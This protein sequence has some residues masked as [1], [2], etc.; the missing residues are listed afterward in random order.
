MK[1]VIFLIIILFLFCNIVYADPHYCYI[2]KEENE[3]VILKNGD[4]I[5]VYFSDNFGDTLLK[6]NFKLYY[7]PYVFEIVKNESGEYVYHDDYVKIKNAKVYS[8]IIEF[9]VEGSEDISLEYPTMYIKFKVKDSAKEGSTII[10]LINNSSSITSIYE[11]NFYSSDVGEYTKIDTN[12]IDCFNAKL[13]YKI[14]NKSDEVLLDSTYSYIGVATEGT[15]MYPSYSPEVTDYVVEVYNDNDEEIG[16]EIS[17]AINGECDNQEYIKVDYKKTKNLK[18]TS[19]NGSSS[20]TYNFKINVID[21]NEYDDNS[22][23]VLT[24]LKV[25]HY[26]LIEEFDSYDRT[27][28]VSIP[29]TE[30]SLLIDYESDFDV[31]IDGNENFK[32]G[33]NIVVITVSNNKYSNKYYIIV[34]KQEK[35]IIEEKTDIKED[36]KKEEV[37]EKPKSRFNGSIIIGLILLTTLILIT[38]FIVKDKKN[39]EMKG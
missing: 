27:Y 5:K 12:K 22:Y 9:D 31:K 21:E 18:I 2:S 10:E 7:D 36:N 35:E 26:D 11:G 28:H 29:D 1:K 37:V 4:E 38:V 3:N 25:L 6:A 13:Y 34:Q 17:C 20:T 15:Y 19:K 14:D 16:I 39:N 32:V 33:E 23:P 8:S 24:D 30:D